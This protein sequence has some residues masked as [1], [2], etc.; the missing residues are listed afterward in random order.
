MF[1]DFLPSLF[2]PLLLIAFVALAVYSF[3]QEK[4]RRE[5][6]R[7]ET[8]ALGLRFEAGKNHGIPARLEFL[9]KLNSGENRY[10]DNVI[11][12]EFAGHGVCC[13]DYHYETHSTDS[14]GKRSTDHH[15]H[16]LYTLRLPRNFPE[17]TIGPE[18]LFTRAAKIFG[19][20]SIDFESAEFSRTFLVRSPDKKFA[21]DVC[22]APMMEYLLENR[23]V[24]I[25]IDRDIYALVFSGK[26]SPL[27]LGANLDRLVTLR[28]K[29][30]AY[31]FDS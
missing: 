17:L 13:F 25:E 16:H 12:G 26:S 10:A 22:H 15:W 5:A 27:A 14:K 7:M 30:P 18:N 2:I 31:L 9:N 24:T 3:Q 11:S 21:Y 20:Q 23:D 28:D 29:L 1:W 4:K 19:Y 6:F 8:A